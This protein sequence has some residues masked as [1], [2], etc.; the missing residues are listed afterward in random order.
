[1]ED[2]Q[3]LD[4]LYNIK[5]LEDKNIDRETKIHLS[6]VQAMVKRILYNDGEGTPSV[7]D[8][9]LIIIDEAHRGYTLDKEMGDD[10]LEFRNQ[11]DFVSKYRT[12]IEYFDA[13][14]IAVTATPALHTTEIFGKPVFEYSYREAVLDG[15]LVDYNL[16]HQII[17]KLRKE[18]VHYQKGDTVQIFDPEKNE[19]TDFS[20]L[21]DELDF[22]INQFNKKII[23]EDFNRVVLN[24]I[25]QDLDPEGQGKT[26]IFA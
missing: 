25:A 3:T 22:D 19:I 10:E 26:L 12:V 4:N 15:F 20:E 11:E 23:I 5:G 18:G 17:T 1:M 6:T 21:E 2:L 24:E 8:Y 14:K 7:S 9:D 16:P 13:V